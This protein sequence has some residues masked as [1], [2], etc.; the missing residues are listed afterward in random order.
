MEWFSYIQQEIGEKNKI[1]KKGKCRGSNKLVLHLS[2]HKNYVIHYRN[3]KFIKD[4]GV[5]IGDVHKALSFLI[6]HHG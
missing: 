3:L 4:L 1:I 2:E 5:E 6:N